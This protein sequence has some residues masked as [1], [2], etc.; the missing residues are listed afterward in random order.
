[1]SEENKDGKTVRDL[2]PD[3]DVKGGVGTKPPESG[4]TT[5]TG[6]TTKGAGN[7]IPVPPTPGIN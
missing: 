2:Q 3:K 6:G 4:D 7:P 1:M 5:K